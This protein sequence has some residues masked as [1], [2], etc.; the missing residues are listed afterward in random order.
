MNLRIW[1]NIMESNP[2]K[3]G[4]AAIEALQVLGFTIEEIRPII[5]KLIGISLAWIADQVGMSRPTV[6]RTI[7]GNY[8]YGHPLVL[9]EIAKA[10]NI[11]VE[12]LFPD[13]FTEQKS[14]EPTMDLIDE[15]KDEFGR[16]LT[17]RELAQLL[18]I[19]PRTVNRHAH[20]WGGI[21]VSPH[22]YRFF[23]KSIRKILKNG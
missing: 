14:W 11:P 16:S 19:D 5:P 22:R 20:R 4:Q 15:L 7:S 6:T 23:E 13:K 3:N 18:R 1:P 9:Q 12:V 21:E 8:D 17:A 2:N 10:L